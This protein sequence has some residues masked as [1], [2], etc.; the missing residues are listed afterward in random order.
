MLSSL[1]AK[2]TPKAY[3]KDLHEAIFIM[4]AMNYKVIPIPPPPATQALASQTFKAPPIDGSLTVPE[5]FDWHL[6]NT[7]NHPLF[8]YSDEH[9]DEHVLL[10]PQGVRAIHQSARI[11]MDRVRPRGSEIPVVAILAAAGKLAGLPS[12]FVLTAS[13]HFL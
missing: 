12:I 8:V 5:L 4:S 9:G 1:R 2:V 11:V 13:H 3:S 6:R 7:P 10:W